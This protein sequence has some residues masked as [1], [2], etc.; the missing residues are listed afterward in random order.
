MALNVT[1]AVIIPGCK[2]TASKPSLAQWDQGQILKIEGVDLP[3]AYQVEFCCRG[4]TVTIT[5][6]G[7]EDGV[8]IPNSLLQRG[9]TIVG[10]L[11][12]HEGLDD[13]ETEYW[14]D[15]YVKAR[16]SPQDVTPSPEEQSVIDELIAALNAGVDAAEEAQAK[17]EDA[18]EAAEAAVTHYPKIEDRYWY[19]WLDGEWV[20][21]GVKAEG[22]DGRGIVSVVGDKSSTSGLVDTY[23]MTVTYTDDNT[24]TITFT[25]TNGFS[26]E[27][28]I[29]PVTHGHQVT[30]TDQEHPEGQTFVILDGEVTEAELDD[31]KNALDD[32]EY[33]VEVLKSFHKD[34]LTWAQ[35]QAIVQSGHAQEWFQIGD[36]IEIKWTKG[37][38]EH[39]LQFDVVSFDNV[40]KYGE[41][42][43]SPG[44]WLQ[45]HYAMDGVQF[46][47]N[48]AFYVVPSGGLEAGTY[49]FTMGNAWGSNVV[50]DKNYQF[51]LTQNYAEGAQLQLGKSNS[52]ISA[53]PDTAPS[54]WRVRTY[55]D[56]A[57]TTPT[58][59]LELTE[60]TSGTFLGTLSSSTLYGTSGL[61]NMQ[62][63]GYGYNRWSQSGMRQ[64][65]NSDAAANDWW[66][67]QNPY[68]RPPTQLSTLAG[69]MAGFDSD[70]LAVL[71]KIKVTT[72]LNTV[73]DSG[74]GTTEDTYDTFFLPSLEQEYIVP[75]LADVE[76][77]YWPYW[78]ERLDL[79][80]PQETGSS[81]ANA[82]HIRYGYDA[83]TTALYCRL[84]SALRGY[85]GTTWTVSATGYANSNYA[86]YA[87]RGCP[88]C[89]IC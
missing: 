52:E 47:Q 19:V 60:G 18:Q 58:E 31:V 6:I 16:P 43:P 89:V 45:S 69:F 11:V 55:P 32:V 53:L 67:Q 29:T 63:S 42:T 78:K 59:T 9:E 68:D 62:R 82:N 10:Y 74:I 49:Y 70:F 56:A 85:A 44:M 17:A 23:T 5:Q 38:T 22:V 40:L 77:P 4:D 57:T 7:N 88:A 34:E 79:S 8:P 81:N 73:S 33:D 64:Y 61:N 65:L 24:D 66:V 75:Q 72:A 15:I 27:V 37:T 35:I 3:Q 30:I 76:G 41:S 1:T 14:I 48:E 71:G 26:P 86:T 87:I 83:K 39:T 80:S 36:Q 12:L 50:K 46:D 51:T 54:D 25:V 20:N 28:T 84:R 21:T 2:R 13:R